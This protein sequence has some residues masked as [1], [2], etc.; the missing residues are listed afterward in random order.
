V[1][2]RY[3]PTHQLKRCTTFQGR[4]TS[5]VSKADITFM[6]TCTIHLLR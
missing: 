1:V 5:Q 3:R 6:D 4:A 2:L